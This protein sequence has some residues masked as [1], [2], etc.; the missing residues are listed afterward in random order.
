MT[1]FQTIIIAA[2]FLMAFVACLFIA[3]VS[4]GR[5]V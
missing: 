5:P 3:G 2:P 1:L 4:L